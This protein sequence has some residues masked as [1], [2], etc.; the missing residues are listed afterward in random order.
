MAEDPYYYILK[1]PDYP[2]GTEA[3]PMLGR[4]VRYYGNPF[5]AF[6][7]DDT[8][9]FTNGNIRQS[10][11]DNFEAA[12]QSTQSS[13]LKLRLS[14]IFNTSA[15]SNATTKL[16]LSGKILQVRR[17]Q[18]CEDIFA[19]MLQ[20]DTSLKPRLKTWLSAGGRPAFM[21]VGLILWRDAYVDSATHQDSTANVQAEVEINAALHASG[22][23]S[24]IDPGS[25]AV[26]GDK[27]NS[28][29][30]KL[31]GESKG[32]H[33][34]ALEYRCVRRPLLSS[35]GD[36]K[37]NSQPR[38]AAGRSFGSSL[39]PTQEELKPEVDEDEEFFVDDELTPWTMD[40]SD[41]I[42]DGENEPLIEEADSCTF[43]F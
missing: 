24:P 13:S 37:L 23:L 42:D 17:L 4:I 43:V 31:K 9:A 10:K 29:D 41:L 2:L 33:V 12:V 16:D 26:N 35:F 32:W 38:Y 1:G 25:I 7:P 30:R 8:S 15:A 39:T 21:I 28:Q 6:A 36:F 34:F 14:K 11:L 3:N 22:I 18:Q 20:N 27:E 5:A 40:L 19:E